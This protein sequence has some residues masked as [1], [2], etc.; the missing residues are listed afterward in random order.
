M[1]LSRNCKIV[2][3]RWHCIFLTVP[4]PIRLFWIQYRYL[5]LS[6]TLAWPL[7]T[8]EKLW[9]YTQPAIDLGSMLKHQ[10]CAWA[11]PEWLSVLS[12]CIWP[13]FSVAMMQND[14]RIMLQ[15]I[16]LSTQTL[17]VL[18]PPTLQ[19]YIT[20]VPLNSTSTPT[21]WTASSTPSWPRWRFG[22]PKI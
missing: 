2:S 17:R 15:K 21:Q 14:I 13:L 5:L 22:K 1:P 8:L 6:K 4:A 16:L 9:V 10:M 12:W 19:E 18:P 11:M 3:L 7:F 20:C